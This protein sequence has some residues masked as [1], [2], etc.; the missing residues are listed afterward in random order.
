[1]TAAATKAEPLTALPDPPEFLPHRGENTRP[2]TTT[3][4]SQLVATSKSIFHSLMHDELR[5]V[6]RAAL[7]R[8]LCDVD[9]RIRAWKGLPEPGQLRPD[10][11]PVRGLKK[12]KL[13]V[14]DLAP[15]EGPGEPATAAAQVAKPKRG[16]FGRPLKA[17]PAK[18]AEQPAEQ[19]LTPK[20]SKP[21]P[22]ED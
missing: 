18:V 6:D 13:R 4:Y 8:A 20:P 9:K 3:A 19:S 16:P 11:D 10:S 21:E 22:G 14:L 12:G 2:T 17:T 5:P 7:A 1:M 15:S